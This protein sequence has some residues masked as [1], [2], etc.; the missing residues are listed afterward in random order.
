MAK[1]NISQAARLTGKSRTT[2]HRKL[3]SGEL[4]I[5]S[6]LID[7]SELI[8]VFGALV[9]ESEQ[10]STST[11]RTKRVTTEQVTIHQQ[12]QL[13]VLQAKLE[14]AHNLLALKDALLEEKDKR[15]ALLEH[16]PIDSENTDN[17][18]ITARQSHSENAIKEQFEKDRE[19][20]GRLMKFARF[21]LD[22]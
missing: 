12:V 4:S 17:H 13:E 16:R 18:K 3:N 1:V 20:E 5:Q 21:V 22:S 19:K 7:T 10:N 6:S 9:S 8:R 2:I 15:L 14:A 11:P